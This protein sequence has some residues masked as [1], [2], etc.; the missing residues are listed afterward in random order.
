MKKN[1]TPPKNFAEKLDSL[2]EF[3]HDVDENNMQEVREKLISFGVNPDTLA[4]KGLALI[5]DLEKKEKVKVAQ[6]RRQQL[7]SLYDKLQRIDVMQPIEI[8]RNKLS[9]ILSA[10]GDS[11]FAQAFAHKHKDI[12]EDDLRNLLSDAELLNLFE[13]ELKKLDSNPQE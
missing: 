3:V 4:R 10:E 13:E 8:V 6:A 7:L 11:Q 12:T 9:T 2:I 1:D 5:L